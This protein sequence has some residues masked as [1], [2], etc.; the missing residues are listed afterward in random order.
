MGLKTRDIKEY[1]RKTT[2]KSLANFIW[3]DPITLTR[4][5]EIPEKY[6]YAVLYWFEM[7][8]DEIIEM[9]NKLDLFKDTKSNK[10][11]NP[12]KTWKP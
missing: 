7:R 8:G 1:S 4:W 11:D 9:I 5:K 6:K 10:D 2:L 3:V 12:D